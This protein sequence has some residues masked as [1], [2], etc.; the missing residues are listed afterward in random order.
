MPTPPKGQYQ[1]ASAK[2]RIFLTPPDRIGVRILFDESTIQ[3]LRNVPGS[4]WESQKR[5]WSFPRTREA[6]EKLLA[7]LRI[8][9]HQLDREVAV[10]LGLIKATPA[11][12]KPVPSPHPLISSDL[13]GLRS[14]LRIRNYSSKTI[15]SYSSCL[16][17]FMRFFSPRHPCNLSESDVRGFL[18]HLLQV[19]KLSAASVDQMFNALRFLYVEVYKKPFVIESLPRPKKEKKLP[20]VLSQEEMVRL[21]NSVTN[22]KHRAMLMVAYSSGVRV[23]ELVQLR[24]EDIDSDRMLIHVRG[25]KRKKDRY[26]L[27][28]QTAL[29]YLRAHSREHGPSGWLFEGAMRGRHYSIRSAEEVFTKAAKKAGIVKRVSIHALRHSFATHLLENGVDLRY[30][31]EL[32]GHESSRTTEIYTHVSARA[33][34]R[35]VSPL[36]M[37]KERMSISPARPKP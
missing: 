13:E 15:K 5:Y 25:G 8:D 33:L 20:N 12:P 18:L 14:E 24:M 17:T 23:S 10:E 31:Q 3:R 35:I 19:E 36:D 30:I 16:R 4:R 37:I 9:W 2:P 27:L 26:T 21:V 34:R 1:S 22:P 32:L 11:Q 28:S 6:L 7:A 29:D